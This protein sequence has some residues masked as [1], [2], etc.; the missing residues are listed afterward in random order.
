MHQKEMQTKEAETKEAA[1]IK[2]KQE[3]HKVAHQEAEE[4][5]R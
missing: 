1:K 3:A 4:M 5:R 2:E